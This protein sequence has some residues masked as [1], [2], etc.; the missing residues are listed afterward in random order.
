MHRA[1]IVMSVAKRHAVVMTRDGEF[2]RIPARDGMVVGAEVSWEVREGGRG[3]IWRRLA[4]SAAAAVVALTAGFAFA[5]RLLPV[6][7]AYAY[8]SLDINP[9]VS[10][11]VDQRKRVIWDQPLNPDGQALLAKVHARN[12]G[13]SEVIAQLID[14]SVAGRMMPADDTILISAAPAYSDH[15]VDDVTTV[16]VTAVQAA[17]HHNHQA[18][19]LHPSV[20]AIDLS[21][22]VWQAATEAHLSPGK[23][24]AYLVAHEE[25]KTLSLSDLQ[26]QTLAKV[27]NSANNAKSVLRTL[28]S[29]DDA[30]MA[31][32]V[33]SLQSSGRLTVAGQSEVAHTTTHASQT[34]GAGDTSDSSS[35]HSSTHPASSDSSTPVVANTLD[36]GTTAGSAGTKA[37]RR[38]AAKDEQRVVRIQFGDVTLWVDLGP[39]AKPSTNPV[40]SGT[41]NGS[42]FYAVA[43]KAHGDKARITPTKSTASKR[44]ELIPH[45]QLTR[46]HHHDSRM[47]LTDRVHR[48]A[49]VEHH[50]AHKASG[51]HGWGVWHKKSRSHGEHSSSHGRG[52]SS[53]HQHGNK[54]KGPVHPGQPLQSVRHKA[55]DAGSAWR[56]GKHDVE[57][58]LNGVYRALR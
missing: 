26:G 55:L 18:S 6:P 43:P 41:G 10:L 9:S 15:D 58:V 35:S 8:V 23:L 53:S 25:G 30:A 32:L 28:Q 57:G 16:A 46:G 54:G 21:R 7:H 2:C 42:S 44:D 19:A 29:G 17:I 48:G 3:R 5:G 31:S 38:G 24:A 36:G 49:S 56:S 20:C 12:R 13:L 4:V 22:T 37:H 40:R 52:K 34:G 1:G 27:L 14:A 39:V 50:A 11:V 51:S 47:V 33:R 45:H